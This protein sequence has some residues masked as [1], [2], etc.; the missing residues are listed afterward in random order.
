ML[1]AFADL[2]LTPT[3]KDETCPD[4]VSATY[5]LVTQEGVNVSEYDFEL[6]L[7]NW[8]GFGA[9]DLRLKGTVEFEG[10]R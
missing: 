5:S 10:D 2:K 8:I 6:S 9:V 3:E 1:D 7:D 4:M